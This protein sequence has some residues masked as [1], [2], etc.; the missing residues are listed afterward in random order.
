MSDSKVNNKNIVRYNPS[1][2]T[3]LSALQ[4]NERFSS[5][6]TNIVETKP[7]KSYLKI[8]ADNIFTFFNMLGLIVTI[9]LIAVGAPIGDF[10]F[11]FIYLANILI[12]IIQEIRAKISIDRLCLL[13][14]K[15]VTVIRDGNETTIS[16]TE[17]VLDDVLKLGV[18]NQIPTDCKII[19]GEIEVNES[20]LTGESVPIKKAID[21]E[22]L[23]GSYVTSGVCYALAHKVGKDC[24][25]ETLQ[26]KAKKYKKPRSELMNSLTNIIKFISFLIIPFVVALLLKHFVL[27]S[28]KLTSTP[29][30]EAIRT[31]A[32]SAIGMIPSGMFL[33]TSMALAVGI[34]KLA[35]H[36]T[37][38][39]DLY[40]LEM[41]ARVDTICFDK[42]GTITDGNMVVY[43]VVTFN[44]TTEKQVKD[45]VSSMIFALKD[46]STTATALKNKFGLNN[47]LTATSLIHFNSTR[48]YS[49]ATFDNGFT[50][51]L[52]APEFVFNKEQLENIQNQINEYASKGFRVLIL[53]ESNNKIK[54]ENLP[55]DLSPIA[56]LLLV[57]N[58]RE[59]A[60]E[61]IKWFKEND[62]AIKVISGDNPITVSQVS[63][64]AGIDYA[65]NYISLEGLSD[66]EIEVIANDYTVFGRVTPEQKAVLIKA[67]KKAKHVV[68][69]TGDGVNDIL[70]LKAA[71][72]AISIV[73]GSD[74]TKSVSDLVLMNNNF[75]SMPHI[76]NEGRR[77]INNVQSSAS[78][79]LMKTIFTM[80]INV[81]T[82]FFYSA[83][84]F[85][86]S[87]MVFVEVFIIGCP[88]FFLSLQ[89][90]ETRVEG[91][92]IKKVIQKCIPSAVLMII[93]V[94]A[95]SLFGDIV[96]NSAYKTIAVIALT[97]AGLLSL[98]NICRPLNKYRSIL[99]ISTCGIALISFIAMLINTSFSGLFGL[100]T[101]YPFT[102][103]QIELNILISVLIIDIPLSIGL[104]LLF[105]LLN[106]K[107][108]KIKQ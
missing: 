8:F 35:K 56:L 25:A 10:F 105:N 84:P 63:K 17:I 34:I 91:K 18:G 97:F 92:F 89:P 103:Y 44:E 96:N 21:D 29:I 57:D 65:D 69:M 107:K 23:S 31:V 74:A 93:N 36:K 54:N 62:V 48:K 5:K 79:F 98:L 46:E 95:I 70:A 6:L 68:A 15:T 100:T 104:R 60:I 47:P 94:L 22:I 39:K 24:Y 27:S 19:K 83:Y 80:V 99:L 87:N 16:P 1:F 64:R 42:T 38:V 67:L 32:T 77:V 59:D 101:I 53:A 50:Y 106:T 55:K 37:H 86:L 11:A 43:D 58:I 72:C 75:N 7:S 41:L 13:S 40:S 51:V 4:V 28:T 45:I 12:G 30:E 78:L 9:A 3:G 85:T 88:A 82:L 26:A 14:N 33:L 90:N 81:L 61:T 71:D 52:G 49:A 76:V 66:K 73:A 108:A 102:N 20:L 2:Q